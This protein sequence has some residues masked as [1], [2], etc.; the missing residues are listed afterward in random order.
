MSDLVASS[1]NV[2]LAEERDEA[3]L[4]GVFCSSWEREVATM[5]DPRIVHHVLRIQ[6][7]TQESRFRTRFSQLS[8]YILRDEEGRDAG[9]LLGVDLDVL[10]RRRHQP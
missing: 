10:D 8:R 5:P 1:G 2:R 4:Y 3:F 7:T 9:R 6:Y